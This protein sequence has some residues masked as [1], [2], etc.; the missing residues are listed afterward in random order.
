MKALFTAFIFS[1][2]FHSPGISQGWNTT[3]LCGHVYHSISHKPFAKASVDVHL[4]TGLQEFHWAYCD[5]NGYYEIKGLPEGV[6]KVEC[7]GMSNY[8]RTIEV[9]SVNICGAVISLDFYLS[10]NN[11]DALKR[12]MAS[13]GVHQG[14]RTMGSIAIGL[15]AVNDD[16][17]FMYHRFNPVTTVEL[18]CQF[19]FDPSHP[20]IGP[21]ITV[22]RAGWL[23]A[24]I[25]LV[26]FTDLEKGSLYL[27]PHVGFSNESNITLGFGYNFRLGPDALRSRVNH[28][29]LCLSVP[30]V[31]RDYSRY[32]PAFYRYRGTGRPLKKLRGKKP[33]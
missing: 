27:A 10:R 3:T 28:F 19:N 4:K 20:L 25:G 18:G 23:S 30:L 31:N 29:D 16:E 11:E 15:A 6:Y 24:D 21:N 12:P 5:S 9:D 22:R 7:H 17:G 26:Y 13:F 8:I 14:W 33:W 2:A 1:I 32:S